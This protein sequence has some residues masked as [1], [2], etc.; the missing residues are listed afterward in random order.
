MTSQ[1]STPCQARH[2]RDANLAS[3]T[4]ADS[5]PPALESRS[6]RMRGQAR[7]RSMDRNVE[8]MLCGR[9]RCALEREIEMERTS[10]YALSTPR[11][12]PSARS[13]LASPYRRSLRR[14]A[15]RRFR[16][17]LIIAKSLLLRRVAQEKE[18]ERGERGKPGK[19]P[20]RRPAQA[21]FSH[22]KLLAELTSP[23]MYVACFG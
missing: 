2:E 17:Q 15:R 18:R 4:A 8:L 9:G 10:G 19:R 6:C 23:P 1:S 12:A 20:E 22:W 7:S 21:M 13:R 5:P 11:P 16:E 14:G 3:L